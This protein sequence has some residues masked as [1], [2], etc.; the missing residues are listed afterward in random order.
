[1]LTVDKKNRRIQWTK[2]HK[3]DDFIQTIFTD[4]SSFQLFRNT[5]RRWTKNHNNA[6]KLVPKNRQK[7]HVW[8][9]I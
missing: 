1:M 5:V 2:D 6:L 3:D 9:A 7:V 4:E 8:G